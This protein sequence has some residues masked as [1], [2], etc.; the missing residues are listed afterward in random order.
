M[1]TTVCSTCNG[2]GLRGFG[3][4]GV[5]ACPDCGGA[6]EEFY[7]EGYC[8]RCE[9][10]VSWENDHP[11][12]TKREAVCHACDKALHYE[13]GVAT[14][15]ARIIA[16]LNGLKDSAYPPSYFVEDILRGIEAG[17]HEKD[18]GEGRG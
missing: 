9:C 7:W 11:P 12:E 18:A 1:T 15:R 8:T 5:G 3:A 14:E 2:T 10:G 6:E 17:D 4:P 16:V 13:E